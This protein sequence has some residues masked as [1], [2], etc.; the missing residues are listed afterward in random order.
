MRSRTVGIVAAVLMTAS[1][2]AE[3]IIT[4]EDYALD[5]DVVLE[6]AVKEI[7]SIP[8]DTINVAGDVIK[9]A[10]DE[11]ITTANGAKA[12]FAGATEHEKAQKEGE[13][14][15]EDA[16]D[17]S[18]NILFR[19]YTVSDRIGDLLQADAADKSAPTVDVTGFFKS[20]PFPRKTSARYL[21]EFQCL[22][23]HQTPENLLAIEKVLA[24]YQREQKNLMGH[25]V[26]IETKFIE[27]GQK[28]LNELGFGW[29]FDSNDGGALQLFDDLVLPVGQDLLA[30]G[31]R[32]ASMAL[33]GAPSAGLLAVSKNTGSFRWGL[34]ISALEQ[35]DDSDVLS[36]PR[37]VTRDR[38]PAIIQV[39]EDQ[40]IPKSFEINKQD[41]SPFVQH[42]DWDLELMGVYMEVTPEIRNDG[43]INLELHPKVLD[44][45]GYDSYLITPDY[46][47]SHLSIYD[48]EN[49]NGGTGFESPFNLLK[50]LP[51]VNVPFVGLRGDSGRSIPELNASLPYLRIREL[52]TSVTV[53]DG[54]T[55]GMGGLIYDK[56]ETFRDKVPVLG[57]IPFLGRLFRSEGER[58]VKRNL[59]I[60]VT[61]TQVDVDGRRS[62]D[63]VLKK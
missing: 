48:S 11:T 50:L 43:L 15:V 7:K 37:V 20:V 1:G 9:Y 29:R 46:V 5:S 27:V 17:A 16:W 14:A 28:T 21:P 44:L 4:A 38:S 58:S 26:E 45:V 47:A 36:A 32:T 54:S 41:T 8:G 40:M 33:G 55:V 24:G 56:L 31:L 42:A 62:A 61:A 39:G 6:S 22:F 25:Q 59:M 19:S 18:N 51:Q 49:P 35:S 10:K 34:L 23:V 63:L 57:S 3:T 52:E 60:F 13:L 53:A 12:I 2:F 30:S